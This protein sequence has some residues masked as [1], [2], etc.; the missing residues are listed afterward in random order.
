[1]WIQYRMRR[2]KNGDPNLIT[3]DR[4]VTDEVSVIMIAGRA[5]TFSTPE[6]ILI[7][8]NS[9]SQFTSPI[10]YYWEYTPLVKIKVKTLKSSVK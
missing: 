2:I 9:F 10:G 6:E 3:Y 8:W 4:I 1:M 7:H 5:L